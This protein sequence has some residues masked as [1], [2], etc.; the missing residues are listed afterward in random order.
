M[1]SR[2][3]SRS[4]VG[5]GVIRPGQDAEDQ[6]A[7][8][9]RHLAALRRGTWLMALIVVPITLV[10]LVLSL[11]LPKTYEAT[12]RLVLQ[13]PAG[14]IDTPSAETTTRQLATYSTLLGS[15]SVLGE[16]ARD[17]PGES[18]DTLK[19]KIE[20]ST[21]DQANIID[22]EA[23]DN[24]AKGAAALANGVAQTFVEGRQAAARERLAIAGRNLDRALERL[25][26]SGASTAEIR[27]L[28]ARRNQLSVDEV[29]AGAGVELAE[30]ADVPEAAASPRPLQNTVFAFFGA[31]FL[32]ILAALGRGV[33]QPRLTGPRQLASLTGLEP[34]VVVPARL[35][36]QDEQEAYQALAASL[37]LQLGETQRIVLVTSPHSGPERAN[38]AVGLGRALASI[39]LPTLLVSA[40]LRRPELHKRLDLPPAPGVGEI[41]SQLEQ[42]PEKSAAA[43]IRHATRAEER[44]ERGE[45]RA[46]PSGD[47]SQHPAALLSGESLGTMFE[48]LENTEYRYVIVEGPSLLGPI[49]G[50][51]VARWADAVLVVCRLDSISPDD[52][53][54]LGDAL[55]RLH[56]PVLGSV[57]I[58]GSQVRYA[59]PAWT[60]P[61]DASDLMP[62]V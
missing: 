47:T 20:V 61:R 42:N 22:V 58:G 1:F 33:M 23:R 28:Q 27:A 13:D 19:D 30:K 12:A 2:M 41:L 26:A 6:W 4:E 35:R 25:K 54:E 7:D 31:L 40:D 57:V 39:G 3:G 50:Q 15:S 53:H 14:T 38:V 59:L 49:D 10:V 18:T 5:G 62:K 9:P 46:L 29:G 37:R 56:Q 55:S 36:R 51:L 34:L 8:V 24:S 21:D 17:F 43:L 16:A 60:T 52:A 48:H 45:L 44:P 11:S 32:A